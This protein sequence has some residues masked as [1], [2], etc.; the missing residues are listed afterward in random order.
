MVAKMGGKTPF[1]WIAL[2]QC[3]QRTDE[4]APEQTSQ[5][6]QQHRNLLGL[7]DLGTS[8]GL[9]KCSSSRLL[10]LHAPVTKR[11]SL[12]LLLACLLGVWGQGIVPFP[13]A[14]ALHQG[15]ESLVGVRLEKLSRQGFQAYHPFMHLACLHPAYIGKSPSG[16]RRRHRVVIVVILL[17]VVVA[18]VVVVS[19]Q[20]MGGLP[21]KHAI[22]T[23]LGVWIAISQGV[24]QDARRAI[25]TFA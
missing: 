10:H 25:Q 22:Q 16:R 6:Q 17:V 18:V 19:P 13:C 23:F 21:P 12:P 11:L 1:V 8:E 5:Q 24:G 20:A 9:C 2:W 4:L 14:Q 3:L 7:A 15:L